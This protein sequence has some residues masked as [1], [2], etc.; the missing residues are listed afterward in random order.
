[1]ASGNLSK[2]VAIIGEIALSGDATRVTETRNKLVLERGLTDPCAAVQI[3]VREIDGNIGY[4]AGYLTPALGNQVLALFNVEHPMFG[5]HIPEET[6]EA[7]EVGAKLGKQ[8]GKT[9]AA[10]EE[11]AKKAATA[12]KIGLVLPESDET[13]DSERAKEIL[14][15]LKAQRDKEVGA[16]LAKYDP[17]D[18]VTKAAVMPHDNTDYAPPMAVGRVGTP[19]MATTVTASIEKLVKEMAEKM[20]ADLKAKMDADL[21]AKIAAKGDE[22]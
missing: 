14:T 16:K 22:W 13:V 8:Y 11:A 4:L 5:R 12:A 9:L 21:K 18:P 3:I 10:M 1:M 7:Y 15:K 17:R 19:G 20:D 2:Q 6:Q